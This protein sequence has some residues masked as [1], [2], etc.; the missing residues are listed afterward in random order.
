MDSTTAANRDDD[1]PQLGDDDFD[2]LEQMLVSGGPASLLDALSSHLISAGRYHELFEARLMAARHALGLPA[3]D[4]TSLDDVPS[5]VREQLEESYFLACREVGA[6][7]LREGRLREAW[8]YL[9]PLGEKQAIAD[10]IAQ[11]KVTPDNVELLIELALHEGLSPKLGYELVLAHYGTCS[12]I[13]MFDSVAQGRSL[14]ERDEL[15]RTLVRHLHRELLQNLAADV[16]RRD[17]SATPD[18]VAATTSISALLGNRDWL[19]ADLNYHVDASHLAATVRISRLTTDPTT[20]R[21]ACELCEYGRRLAPPYQFA[22][23][24][25]FGDLYVDSLRYFRALLGEEVDSAVEFFAQQ[26]RTAAEGTTRTA[27]AEVYVALLASLGRAEEAL[28]VALEMLPSGMPSTGLAPRI[29]ELAAAAGGFARVRAA[30][31]ARGDLLGYAAAM[32][33]DSV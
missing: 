16:A 3:Q 14:A 15:A 2:R 21:L 33:A 23:E 12:A 27:P 13:T 25:P 1:R 29:W 28:T 22:S 24:P 19:F 32:L 20:L 8:M 18:E 26:T 11:T 9:Q 7:F 17:P 5:G 31:R 6:A 10:K 4:R 30:C